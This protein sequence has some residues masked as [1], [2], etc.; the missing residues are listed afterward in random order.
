[1]ANAIEPDVVDSVTEQKPARL[2]KEGK[3]FRQQRRGKIA[4]LPDEVRRELDRRLATES[5]RNYKWL[6]EWLE[7]DHA[8][9]ISPSAINYYK[10]HHIDLELMPVKYATEEA[11]R[12]V[13][14]TGGDNDKIN[15]ILTMLV[16]TK[17]F[18]MLIDMNR[19][20]QACE[21]VERTN[22]HSHNV[23]AARAERQAG[24]SGTALVAAGSE[25]AKPV[26]AKYPPQFVLAAMTTLTKSTTAIGTHVREGEMWDI[27]REELLRRLDTATQKVAKVA[28]EAGL[29]PQVEKK[30]RAA[31]MEIKP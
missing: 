19:T 28:R 24:E 11:Q 1:M 8:A 21:Q 30:I 2:T 3:P 26:E 16:Q 20:K 12:I 9:R 5:F 13:E 17:L 18:D 25:T 29:S 23:L 27:E 4:A 22:E 31:L 15:R 7:Q 6:S 14:A 10:R